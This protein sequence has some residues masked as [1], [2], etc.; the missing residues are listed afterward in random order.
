MGWSN[1]SVPLGFDPAF[2]TDRALLM[3]SL[4]PICYSGKYVCQKCLTKIPIVD[5]E[6]ILYDELKVFF[7]APENIAKRF[8]EAN[9][10]RSSDAFIF[11]DS[12]GVGEYPIAK[13][14]HK[15]VE[16]RRQ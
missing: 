4:A 15:R 3:I 14:T 13:K 12:G 2:K 10:E 8:E 5:L 1:V 11:F 6:A 16:T 7:A 9:Q